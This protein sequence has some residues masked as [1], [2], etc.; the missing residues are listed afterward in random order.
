MVRLRCSPEN[1]THFVGPDFA[2]CFYFYQFF[3]RFPE[4]QEAV[5]FRRDVDERK[6]SGLTWQMSNSR[7]F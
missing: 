5:E 1:L 2:R 4:N 6:C 7:L 3:H